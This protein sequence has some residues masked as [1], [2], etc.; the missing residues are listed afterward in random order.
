MTPLPL[1]NGFPGKIA[2]GYRTRKRETSPPG[3]RLPSA[4]GLRSDRRMRR[5]L[6]EGS[7]DSRIVVGGRIRRGFLRVRGRIRNGFQGWIGKRIRCP[8][9]GRCGSGGSRTGPAAR[10][11]SQQ[12]PGPPHPQTTHENKGGHQPLPGTPPHDRERELEVGVALLG[13]GKGR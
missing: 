11:K 7:I 10:P 8:V 5:R 4:T 13:G 2:F 1:S 3:T 12:E 6:P 9:G